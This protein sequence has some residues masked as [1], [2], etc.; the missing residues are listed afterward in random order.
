MELEL[1][2]VSQFGQIIQDPDIAEDIGARLVDRLSA[3]R[4]D[5]YIDETNLAV[6]DRRVL[7]DCR[8]VELIGPSAG[9]I[10]IKPAHNVAINARERFS[11]IRFFVLLDPSLDVRKLFSWIMQDV[12]QSLM[13]VYSEENMGHRTIVRREMLNV[14]KALLDTL[15]KIGTEGSVTVETLARVF[16]RQLLP[17][18]PSEHNLTIRL[19]DLYLRGLVSR[20]VYVHNQ[21]SSLKFAYTLLNIIGAEI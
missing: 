20:Q 2:D 13:L 16:H 11:L 5:C 10:L 4:S 9:E 15:Q 18:P 19:R 8:G 3:L 1:M 14:P 6:A 17:N 7:L 21:L 12:N